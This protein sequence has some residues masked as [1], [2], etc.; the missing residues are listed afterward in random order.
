MRWLG[1][2]LLTCVARFA[3][4]GAARQHT[5]FVTQIAH[6]TRRRHPGWMLRTRGG[7][8]EG[9]QSSSSTGTNSEQEGDSE[10]VPVEEEDDWGPSLL[11]L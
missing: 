4:V 11:H 6:H 3:V 2:Y 5:F 8:N 10:L 1:T 7:S 9:P